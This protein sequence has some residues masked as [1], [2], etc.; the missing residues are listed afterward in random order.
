MTAPSTLVDLVRLHDGID[1][2]CGNR[3]VSVVVRDGML[4]C[5]GEAVASDPRIFNP[6]H[7]ATNSGLVFEILV[8]AALR[9][10]ASAWR[11]FRGVNFLK[12][13]REVRRQSVL[14]TIAL[15]SLLNN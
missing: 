12:G 2:R 3:P 4:K 11:L 5:L 7:H 1:E 14:E 9:R 13:V 15:A 6:E 10:P 8:L